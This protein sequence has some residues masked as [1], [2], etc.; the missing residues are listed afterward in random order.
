MQNW[1]NE[2]IIMFDIIRL[3]TLAVAI[4][5]FSKHDLNLTINKKNQRKTQVLDFHLAR[6]GFEPRTTGL[7]RFFEKMT[8]LIC[9]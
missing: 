3:K 8:V 9:N 2:I 6:P 5:Y 7:C 4:T 1:I